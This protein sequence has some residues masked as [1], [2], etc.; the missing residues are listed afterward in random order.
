MTSPA[1]VFSFRKV[2][3]MSL[4]TILSHSW[5]VGLMIKCLMSILPKEATPD[6]L[7]VFRELQEK[8][9]KDIYF[10]SLRIDQHYAHLFC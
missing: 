3:E 8:L 10:I 9:L 4:C 1:K 7:N 2:Q 5:F 6:M